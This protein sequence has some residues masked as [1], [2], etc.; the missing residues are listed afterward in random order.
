VAKIEALEALHYVALSGPSERSRF[1]AMT[2]LPPRTGR[3]VLSTLLDFGVLIGDGPR[4]PVR[5]GVP[6][7]SLRFLFPRLWPEAEEA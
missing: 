5:F 3:R 1:I 2:G 7:A 4:S 6:L